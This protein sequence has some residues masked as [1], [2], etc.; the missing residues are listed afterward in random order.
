MD[1][2]GTVDVTLARE[3]EPGVAKLVEKYAGP[4]VRVHL[5]EEPAP[6]TP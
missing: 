5:K 3:T 6:P 2:D 1:A 4:P